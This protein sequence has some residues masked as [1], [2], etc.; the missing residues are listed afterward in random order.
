MRSSERREMQ[1][2]CAR[3][4]ATGFKVIRENKHIVFDVLFADR[5]PVRGVMP[6]SGSDV[7]G[8]KNQEAFLRRAAKRAA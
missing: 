4:G 2:M 7:R 1:R 3:L 5:P 6:A 8:I